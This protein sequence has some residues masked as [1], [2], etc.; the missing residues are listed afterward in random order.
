MSLAQGILID[1]GIKVSLVIGKVFNQ[2]VD[3]TDAAIGPIVEVVSQIAARTTTGSLKGSTGDVSL[4]GSP[5]VV[6]L[7]IATG[8][9]TEAGM[10]GIQVEVK[11]LDG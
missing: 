5:V 4:E 11:V 6:T 7:M 2:V 3:V 9:I 1:S 10:V 8:S